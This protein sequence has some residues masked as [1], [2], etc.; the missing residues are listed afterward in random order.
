MQTDAVLRLIRPGLDAFKGYA[1]IEPVDVLEKRLG[2]KVTKLDGNE[3]P[4]GCS[5]KVHGALRGFPYYHIYPDPAHRQL[6]E[7]LSV[8]T[9]F[10]ADHIVCGNGSDELIDLVLRL[11]LEPGDE[12]INC[13]P[14]FGMYPFCTELC[15]GKLRDVW[16]RED[17]SVDIPGIRRALTER[18]KVII[19]ASPNNPTGTTVMR[20]EVAELLET[21]SVVVVDE[22]YCEFSGTTVADMV[23]EHPNLVVLRTFSKWAGLAG[24]RVGYG[25]VP[26]E[27][28]NLLMKIKP[29]YNVNVAAQV[30]VLAS[31]EDLEDLQARIGML[32]E[33]R[34]K[35]F[36]ELKAVD[37]L[38]PYPSRA[39]FVLCRV[40]PPSGGGYGRTAR[41]VWQTL[42][43]RGVFVRYYESPGLENCLRVS[44]GRPEDTE[45]LLHALREL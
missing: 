39:N 11:F 36:S 10:A 26:V 5:P 3:N 19:V 13:P 18:T 23:M 35:L 1:A 6:R 7:G 12:V 21:G 40:K 2:G 32:V 20:E 25:I 9:G 38:V 4:Y 28:A 31:L 27:L 17:Y 15:G 30:A 37:W 41:E 24:L 34:E 42:Q 43:A 8:Y 22:A 29:P 14:T 44:A 16:R 45:T 33:E